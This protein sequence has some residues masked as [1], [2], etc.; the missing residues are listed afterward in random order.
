M[1]TYRDLNAWKSAMDLVD[2]V[3]KATK[4]FPKEEIYG[5]VSQMRRSAV[6]VPSNIAE[7]NSRRMR[8][9]YLRFL[10]IAHGSLTELETQV[11]ISLRQNFISEEMHSSIMAQ[12]EKTG[13]LLR[14][15]IIALQK[16]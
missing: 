14:A 8:G 7:G 10:S 15:L 6:S 12:I 4:D 3:Y 13:A 2:S 5:L 9:E 16:R 11:I 1:T